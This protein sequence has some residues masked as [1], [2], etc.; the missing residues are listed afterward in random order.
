MFSR[1]HLVIALSC[2][3]SL[4][5]C[6]RD[7]IKPSNTSRSPSNNSKAMLVNSVKSNNDNG[8][9]IHNPNKQPDPIPNLNNQSEP[10]PNPDEQLKPK[11]LPDITSNNN[12]NKQPKPIASE[13]IKWTDDMQPLTNPGMGFNQ[14]YYTLDDVKLVDDDLSIDEYNALL[15]KLHVDIISYRVS[16]E[17]LEPNE[18]KYNWAYIENSAVPLINKGKK[19]ALKFYT[20]FLCDHADMQATPLWVRDAGARGVALDCDGYSNNNA[21]AANYDDPILLTKLQNFYKAAAKRYDGRDWVSFIELGSIGRVGEGTSYQVDNIPRSLDSYKTHIDLLRKAFPNTQ[22]I[23]NDD[24]GK[25]AVTYALTQ[26][27]GVDDHSISVDKSSSNPNGRAWN[28]DVLSLAQ[29]KA[30]IGLEID[31][32]LNPSAFYRQNIIESGANFARLHANPYSLLKDA[33]AMEE[34]RKSQLAIGYRLQFPQIQIPSNLVAGQTANIEY[35]VLNAGAG[36]GFVDFQPVFELQDQSGHVISQVRDNNFTLSSLSPTYG[37]NESQ[38]TTKA[39][40]HKVSLFIPSNL[41][42]H[43]GYRLVLT[44]QNAMGTSRINLPYSKYAD[45][46]G[47]YVLKTY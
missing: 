7:R 36:Y 1:T 38:A 21:W 20:N 28:K 29:S 41:T 27:Y 31:T 37:N 33:D 9:I 46:Q 39:Q 18:G 26:G 30:P 3:L 40:V 17:K 12:N 2:I 11:P 44:L 47:V 25:E 14:M 13:T 5:A 19:I 23:I 8:R 45:G 16:W 22:L 32:F 34:L 4:T 42:N 10:T 15:D 43:S 6:N 24:L 35:M